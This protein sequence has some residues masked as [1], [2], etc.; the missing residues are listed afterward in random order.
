MAESRNGNLLG[1]ALSQLSDDLRRWLH[2]LMLLCLASLLSFLYLAQASWVAKHIAEMETLDND[3]R[4]LKKEYNVLLLPI[5]QYKRMPRTKQKARAL[6]LAEP[7]HIEYVGVV[8]DG[9]APSLGGDTM[10]GSRSFSP[11]CFFTLASVAVQCDGPIQ[12]LGQCGYGT[13][14]AG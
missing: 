4:E 5:A 10:H 3:L 11:Y 6:G 13:R 9:P 7:E 2:V 8:L 1:Q 12:R 14:R